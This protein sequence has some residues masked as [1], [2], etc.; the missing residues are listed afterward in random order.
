M[1]LHLH[2]LLSERDLGIACRYIGSPYTPPNL[3]IAPD[4][5]PYIYRWHVVKRNP[6]AC[7][8]FHIQVL[9]D[10]DRPLHDHPWD[11]Q[12]V[13]LAGGY[14]E[15]LQKR[16]PDGE[17]IVLTRR[18]GDVI[19][20]RATE[21][22]RLLM[23][24]GVAYT[25]TQFTTGPKVRDWGFWHPTKGWMNNSDTCSNESDSSVLKPGVFS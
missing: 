10:P 9:N 14:I 16:P 4:G 23:P 8:Y 7:V 12:S 17:V 1:T 3:T 2:E 22:H 5:D 20:R 25:M 18:P 19:F 11:N 13:I 6:D 15:H 21:A 24:P